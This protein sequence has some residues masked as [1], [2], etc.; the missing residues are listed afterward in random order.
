MRLTG[1]ELAD[2]A[3]VVK[4]ETADGGASDRAMPSA[5]SRGR[6]A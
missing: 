1:S 4:G 5:R 3:A 6:A 2:L